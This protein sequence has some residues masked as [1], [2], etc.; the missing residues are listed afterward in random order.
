MFKDLVKSLKNARLGGDHEE[1]K[2]AIGEEHLD[3]L[4]V[5]GEVTLGVVALVC[6]GTA[7]FESRRCQL[8]CCQRAR[9]RGEAEIKELF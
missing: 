1:A 9:A 5:G 8:V 3:L 7:P 2:E 4:I 6:V